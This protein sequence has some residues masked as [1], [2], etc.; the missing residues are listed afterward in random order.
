MCND[1][2][3]IVYTK[4]EDIHHYH[5]W[6]IYLL[7]RIVYLSEWTTFTRLWFHL[8]EFINKTWTY[9]NNYKKVTPL[10]HDIGVSL[11][12]LITILIS[13]KHSSNF[14]AMYL[15][16]DMIAY[17]SRVLWFDDL[18]PCRT[19][20]QNKVHSHRRILFQSLINFA[21]SIFLFGVFYM[22]YCISSF[23]KTQFFQASFE[24]ATTLGRP[25]SLSSCPSWLIN[26][27]V[28]ISIFFVVAVISVIASVG[29][30]RGEIAP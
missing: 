2:N 10:W 23:C 8:G 16:V 19:R 14:L 18:I 9:D 20:K 7:Y 24:V 3:E 25:D 4:L 1:D 17:N 26:S 15:V 28:C 12:V 11:H 6:L 5:G 22:N 30:K 13:T 27:Q 29:Y 21:E